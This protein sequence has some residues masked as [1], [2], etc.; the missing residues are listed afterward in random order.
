MMSGEGVTPTLAGSAFGTPAYMP[1]E[2]AAGKLDQLGP[3]SD[4]YGLGATLYHLLTGRAPFK[5]DNLEQT[6]K[7]V[8][9][10]T[11]RLT[12]SPHGTALKDANPNH[13][14]SATKTP[15]RMIRRGESA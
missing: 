7:A 3:G 9:S 6:L 5:A 15:R 8:Q 11:F 14:A 10:G 1:P 13:R 4:V 2:Q 12:S